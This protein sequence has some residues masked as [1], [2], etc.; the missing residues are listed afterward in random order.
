MGEIFKYMIDLFSIIS[1]KKQFS[2][3]SNKILQKRQEFYKNLHPL[4]VKWWTYKP[5]NQIKSILNL[6][7]KRCSPY[8]DNVFVSRFQSKEEFDSRLWELF[9]CNLLM[10]RWFILD[11]NKNSNGTPDILIN[12]NNK[13]IWVENVTSS[14]WR[15][16]NIL[17]LW[18][19][20]YQ[21][22][23]ISIPRYIRLIESF[24]KKSNQWEKVYLKNWAMKDDCYI[25]A[26]SG[27]NIEGF[28][29]DKGMLGPLYW[30]WLTQFDKNGNISYQQLRELT[31][32][33]WSKI[34]T[35]FFDNPKYS[36]VSWVIYL[37]SQVS[38]KNGNMDIDER[39]SLQF[40]PNINSKNPIPE[41]FV[42]ILDLHIPIIFT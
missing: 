15:D 20:T 36:H 13:S 32:H 42:K 35:W 14:I 19:W 39:E 33:N 12:Y 18:N 1:Q 11:E 37:E 31:K 5:C 3:K 28:I 22:D 17:P 10:S 41:D 26:I 38:F 24:T 23:E 16:L 2:R 8:L 6:C 7:Y 34:D 40:I 27:V 30:V 29:I 21:S 9:M 4:F 25:I